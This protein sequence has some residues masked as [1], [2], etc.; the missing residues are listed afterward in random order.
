MEKGR[1]QIKEIQ[2]IQGGGVKPEGR[3][4]LLWL[5]F[6][7]GEC[8]K[9]NGVPSAKPGRTHDGAAA[10]IAIRPLCIKHT[11]FRE[12]RKEREGNREK[13]LVSSGQ[14]SI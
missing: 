3:G 2:K 7:L 14:W 5:S 4:V 12:Q 6:F 8:E 11:F 9:G 13:E 10:V 1:Q